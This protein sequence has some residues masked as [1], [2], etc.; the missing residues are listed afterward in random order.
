MATMP[1]DY[2]NNFDPTKNYDRIL[3]R[4]G[5]TLQGAELNE[6][7]SAS[8][9]RLK[10]V[11]DAL[12]KDGDIIRDAQIIVDAATGAVQAQSGAVYIGGAVRGV[13]AATFSIPTTGT[14]VVGVRLIERVVSE[15][16]DPVL[17]NPAIGSRGEGEP[18]AHRLQITPAWAF[19]GDGSSAGE[20]YPVYTIDDGVM[21][22]KEAPPSLDAFTQGIAKYDRDSTAG[23]SYVVSGLL[24]AEALET[25]AGL[26]QGYTVSAGRARVNGYGVELSTD[27]RLHYETVPDL[28]L[29]DT[30]VHVATGDPA[31]RID[32]AHPPIAKVSALRVTRRKTVQLVHGAYAGVLDALPDTAVVALVECKQGS[33]VYVNGT[34]YKKTGDK[35]DW[36]P[37]GAE[38]A[39]GSTYDCTYDFVTALEPENPDADGFDVAGAVAGSSIMVTYQQALPR[40]D[41]LCLTQDGTFQWI[42]GVAA[43]INP[44]TPQV[45]P[46]LLALATIHQTWRPAKQVSTDG[47]RVV[48][49]DE[50]S[51]INRRIDYVLG[52][53]ARQRLESDVYTRESGAR[54]GLFVDP[55]LN[56]DMR[57]QGLKQTAAIVDGELVLPIAGGTSQLTADITKPAALAYT[58]VVLLDQPRRTGS[59]QVNPYMAY[60]PL[61]ARITLTP[62]VDFWTITQSKWTSPI[63]QV[64]SSGSGNRSSSSTST[65]T[66]VVGSKTEQIE[67]LRPI[68]LRFD[69][70]GFGPDE[71]VRKVIFDGIE[72]SFEG[73]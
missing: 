72:V 23:G 38:P 5:Y 14:V 13:P 28:R 12:F 58:P 51:A 46:A 8:T 35:V 49:F 24:V 20:F 33:T 7:Q 36:S 63:T 44:R 52:E 15:L 16:D 50:I 71:V 41:R 4:D 37:S 3:Y 19:D 34:D 55:L 65:S 68:T 61:P 56:D 39:A 53:V 70:E 21:R 26:A 64:F 42:Q 54:I 66:N 1:N 62:P 67:H 2:Y 47:V 43:E 25:G 73:V 57:D 31:Q 10:S 48:P 40:L 32:V 45:P 60:E 29:I 27:R 18:G 69:V 59:M 9:Y 17:Y 6:A 30:E 22:P 11:T